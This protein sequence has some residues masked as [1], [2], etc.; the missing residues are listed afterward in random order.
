MTGDPGAAGMRWLWAL[1]ADGGWPAGEGQGRDRSSWPPRAG[2]ADSAAGS[3]L[4]Q[5]PLLPEELPGA[6]TTRRAPVGSRDLVG[7][8]RFKRIGHNADL[9]SRDAAR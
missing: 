4:R 5:R 2:T 6:G 1:V 7:L 9:T 3:A 8:I